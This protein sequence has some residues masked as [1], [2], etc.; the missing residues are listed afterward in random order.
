M[1]RAEAACIAT[2]PRTSTVIVDL[3]QRSAA[4]D[5]GDDPRGQHSLL[6]ELRRRDEVTEILLEAVDGLEDELLLIY[7]ATRATDEST[8]AILFRR[9]RPVSSEAIHPPAVNTLAQVLFD[10]LRADAPN[11]PL[12]AHVALAL[13]AI[14][15]SAPARDD[16]G[17]QRGG[18]ASWQERRAIAFMEER[19]DQSFPVSDVAEACG[20]SVNHFSRAFRRS[21]GKPPHRWL[22]DRRIQRAQDML[23]INQLSLADIALACGF[24][25]QS[26]FTRVFTRIVGVPP[27]AW[28]RSAD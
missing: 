12:L 15:P 6:D 16:P 22:L 26:H 24:A 10:S 7:R 1:Y 25:E 5:R 4:L 18:L 2:S 14:L 21:I 28:R 13:R 27:G 3:A 8:G 11:T 9:Q 20:L 23:R 17:A 19:L